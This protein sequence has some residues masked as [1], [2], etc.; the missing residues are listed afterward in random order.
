MRI[1]ILLLLLLFGAKG[2]AQKSKAELEREKKENL[3]RIEEAARTLTETG[4]TKNATL[5]QL[6]ALRQQV[7][8]QRRIMASMENEI[9]LLT[10]EMAQ[11]SDVTEALERD[12]E[13]LKREYAAM[14]QAAAR[15]RYLDRLLFL[16]SADTYNQFLRRLQYLRQYGQ[17]RTEQVEQISK[18]KEALLGQQTSLIG[19]R[20]EKEQLLAQQVAE[21]EKLLGLQQE[22]DVLVRRL[23]AQEGELRAELQNRRAA[24]QRLE[25]LIADL[26]RAEIRR[27]AEVAAAKKA[28]TAEKGRV[29]L[30]AETAVISTSFGANKNRLQWPVETGFISRQFGTHPHPVLKGVTVD[31]AGVDIQTNK[32]EKVR[33]V[34]D[35]EVGFVA[36]IPGMNGRIVSIQHGEYFTVY[37]GLKD[38]VVKV[39]QKVKA[40]DII[41]E[42]Y[43]SKEGIAEFQFQV[44][45]NNQRL[46]PQQ[47]LSQR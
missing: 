14:V 18:V 20:A 24:D 29:T 10:A 22:R 42:V 34:F 8:A 6:A 46:N 13:A 11:L 36:S 39:N 16:F 40:R 31:N 15:A 44:W 37:A 35:G 5:G 43:T 3:R 1:Y 17:A 12:L 9:R 7:A 27:S 28:K 2:F 23:S 30:D 32:G 21:N 19:K 45:R 26:I 38:V 47:W 4:S 41:G 25:K 33:A